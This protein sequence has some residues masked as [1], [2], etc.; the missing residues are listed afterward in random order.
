[1]S[2]DE[3]PIVY[4]YIPNSV[5]AVKQQMLADVG[6]ASADEFYADVPEPL[7]LRDT[8]QLPEP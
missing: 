2:T 3:H 6:A 8:L 4:P 7:R 1:M 5:P